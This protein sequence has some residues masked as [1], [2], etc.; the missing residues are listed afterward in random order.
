MITIQLPHKRGHG[1]IASQQFNRCRFCT[2]KDNQQRD[3]SSQDTS[4]KRQLYA[5]TTGQYFLSNRH[6]LWLFFNI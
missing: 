1:H 6:R 3:S 2:K 5:T 4:Q